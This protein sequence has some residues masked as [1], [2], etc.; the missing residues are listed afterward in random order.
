MAVS[1]FEKLFLEFENLKPKLPESG[2]WVAQNLNYF[3]QGR[4]TRH[5]DDNGGEGG[6]ES[7]YQAEQI[8]AAQGWPTISTRIG[9]IDGE[10][11]EEQLYSQ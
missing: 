1:K 4:P 8:P 10:I 2:I 6:E 11:G 7:F 9:G 5:I 3:R